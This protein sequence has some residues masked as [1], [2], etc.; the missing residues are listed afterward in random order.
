MNDPTVGKVTFG[1]GRKPPPES[2]VPMGE[3]RDGTCIG[4]L[5]DRTFGYV[6]WMTVRVEHLDPWARAALERG[7]EAMQEDVL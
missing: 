2:R 4:E 5:P 6:I 1:P 3:L 7:L